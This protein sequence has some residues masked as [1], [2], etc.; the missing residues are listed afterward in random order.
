VPFPL[1]VPILHADGLL[2]RPVDEIDIPGWF[3][4]ASDAEIC[5]LAGDPVVE[6]IEQGAEWLARNKARFS[7]G[8]AV[9]WAIV[10]LGT[11]ESVGTIGLTLAAPDALTANLGFVLSRSHWGRGIATTS[12]HEVVR[13]AFDRLGLQGLYGEVLVINATSRRVMAKLG[14]REDPPAPSP[15]DGEMCVMC[16]MDALTRE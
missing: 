9:R 2:L 5:F 6:R 16:R 4:R 1:E 13:F 10:P 14:F 15:E 7:E 12:G 8:T 3:A 11:A